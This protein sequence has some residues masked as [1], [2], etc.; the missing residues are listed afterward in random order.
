MRSFATVMS[1]DL[2]ATPVALVFCGCLAV[3]VVLSIARLLNHLR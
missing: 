3:V 2:M 1:A